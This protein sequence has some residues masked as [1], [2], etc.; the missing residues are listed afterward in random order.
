MA[1]PLLGRLRRQTGE[2]AA[3]NPAQP[4]R[5]LPPAGVLR[6]E[7]RA[8]L[9][10]REERIR[11][12]GGLMY[13]MYRHDDFRQELIFEQCNELAGIDERLGELE[14]MLSPTALA[15]RGQAGT[16]CACGAPVIWGAHFCPNC[17]RP[18]GGAPIVT[19]ESCGNPLPA[20]ARFCG[21][22]GAPAPSEVEAALAPE[23]PGPEPMPLAEAPNEESERDAIDP[24][25]R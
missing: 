16:R 8:L 21:T 25:E 10:A 14:S 5:R 23:S 2:P 9:R 12:L 6:R 7:R 19:C 13:E 20:D 22:C 24:W 1:V 15:R 4:K 11:D 17:G 18:T 3:G